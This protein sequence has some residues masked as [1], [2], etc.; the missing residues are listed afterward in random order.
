MGKAIY[1]PGAI[2]GKLEFEVAV[3]LLPPP[4][5][6]KFDYCAFLPRPSLDKGYDVSGVCV[7][8]AKGIMA[9]FGRAI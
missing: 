3:T 6:G 2:R 1:F 9:C 7:N 5:V 4:A 8:L